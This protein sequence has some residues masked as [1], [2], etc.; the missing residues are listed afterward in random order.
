MKRSSNPFALEKDI[1]V[2][3]KPGL[4]VIAG[5]LTMA[6]VASERVWLGLVR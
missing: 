3:V 5:G 2:I 1:P 6:F 4:Y